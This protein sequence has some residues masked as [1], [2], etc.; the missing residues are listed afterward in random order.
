MRPTASRTV[1]MWRATR[2]RST[3]SGCPQHPVCASF[4]DGLEVQVLE[5][6]PGLP[7]D[8]R[9]TVA[10]DQRAPVAKNAV[11]ERSGRFVDEHEVDLPL[12]GRF[13]PS[14]QAAERGMVAWGARTELDGDVDV[15]SGSERTAGAGAEQHGIGDVLLFFKGAADPVEH[16]AI[17]VS[18]RFG[19]GSGPGYPSTGFRA[20]SGRIN[21][22]DRRTV[23]ARGVPGG[24]GP[25]L[26]VDVGLAHTPDGGRDGRETRPLP[27]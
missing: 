8:Q 26:R 1:A 24:P 3:T 4:L 18:A 17:V 21:G 10:L 9:S 19:T 20:E 11:C 22:R 2:G 13:K 6:D 7:G 15:A 14:D 16:A 5:N 25:I 23:W 27:P 12:G